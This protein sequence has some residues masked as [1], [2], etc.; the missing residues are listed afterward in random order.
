[1]L[2]PIG[3]TAEWPR[4]RTEQWIELNQVSWDSPQ[5]LRP[6]HWWTSQCLLTWP[7]THQS[8]ALPTE[9]LV[10]WNCLLL[11][12]ALILLFHVSDPCG[13]ESVLF[14]CLLNMF[15]LRVLSHILL[16]SRAFT[17]CGRYIH[18]INIQNLVVCLLCLFPHT[19]SQIRV[20]TLEKLYLTGKGTS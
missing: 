17:N 16:I 7:R 13:S 8:S 1:M 15:V 18:H 10:L 3:L 19:C 14:V 6:C 20:E 4:S 5:E 2:K 12:I 11:L 9:Q